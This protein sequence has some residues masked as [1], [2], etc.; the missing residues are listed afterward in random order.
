MVNGR[1]FHD[2]IVITEGRNFQEFTNEILP[3]EFFF[4]RSRF[5][6]TEI[7]PQL[8]SCEMFLSLKGNVRNFLKPFNLLLMQ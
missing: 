6:Y 2:E 8:F 5:R 1:D 4:Q 7:K 3:Y